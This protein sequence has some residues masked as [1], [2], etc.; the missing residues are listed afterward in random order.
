MG[1]N[2]NL[3]IIKPN[4]LSFSETF[5]QAHIDL[6]A[7][8]KKVLYG[9]SFPLYDH[10]DNFLIT[11][12]PGLLSYL[13]QKKVLKRQ[14]IKVRTQ[15]LA[16]YLKKQ[17][18]DVVLAEY[19][20][21]G[22]MVTE[23]CGMANVP[24]VIHYHGADVH[25]RGTIAE[26]RPFYK[27]SFQ[28]ASALVAVS[29]D[30]LNELKRLGAPADKLFLNPYGVDIHKFFKVDVAASG[31]N[32]LAVGRFVEKKSPSSVI[33]A[34][35][36]VADQF[37]DARLCMAGTGPL[38]D[39]TK[40]FAARLGLTDK[41]AFPGILSAA[42][43]HELMQQTRCFVQ[44]SVTADDGDMEGT[45]NTILEA[46]ASGLPVVSTL[47]AGIKEAVVDGVSGFLTAEHDIEGMAKGMITL[48]GSPGLAQKMGDAGRAHIIANYDI[49]QRITALNK[50]IQNSIAGNQ[51]NKHK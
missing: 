29:T 38:F 36:I 6:L 10:D 40:Q 16:R 50:I 22:A 14:D 8:D 46:G 51:L 35:K 27:R 45:P 18:I 26:F 43:I 15:A 3:C 34:F 31:I 1:D 49:T 28:Y 48:A 7:G 20:M 17:N 44:H 30:M 23:A 47:H 24:L 4:K 42:Q 9:G 12:K 13:V 37:P 25:H 19:G 11:S 39:E 2:Y 41:A 32:F 5:I 21:V 33:R